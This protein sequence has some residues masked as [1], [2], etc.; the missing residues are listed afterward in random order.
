MTQRSTHQERIIRNFYRN[1]EAIAL[2]RAQELL[3]ELYLS[4]G[5]RR[6]QHWRALAGHLETLGLKPEQIDHLV[7]QDN[8]ELAANVV[9][10]LTIEE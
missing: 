6:T 5:K 10:K 7:A 1:R 8:T 9:K 2:Q 4:T 3:T